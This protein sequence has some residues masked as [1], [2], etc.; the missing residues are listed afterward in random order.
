MITARLENDPKVTYACKVILM[1]ISYV[2]ILITSFRFNI[3]QLY[4]NFIFLPNFLGVQF[5]KLVN[6]IWYKTF[7]YLLISVFSFRKN[8]RIPTVYR[9]IEYNDYS[10]MFMQR[11]P[12]TLL[13]CINILTFYKNRYLFIG[14]C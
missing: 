4:G 8:Q 14:F 1:I 7:S 10:V 9:L 5:V 3:H 13:V 6:L 2:N 11:A 12:Q